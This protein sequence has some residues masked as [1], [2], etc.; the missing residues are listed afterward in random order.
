[1]Q[2]NGQQYCL[3]GIKDF[4]AFFSFILFSIGEAYLGR[5]FCFFD[6]QRERAF[7][8]SV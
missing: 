2:K 3:I 8:G 7:S 6:A 1:M 5:T 4:S